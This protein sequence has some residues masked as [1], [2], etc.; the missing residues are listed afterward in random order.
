VRLA[1]ALAIKAPIQY[2]VK[3]AKDPL[4]TFRFKYRSIGKS[5]HFT[6]YIET[7]IAAAALKSLG[8][9]PR[10]PSPSQDIQPKLVKQE[11]ALEPSPEF[12]PGNALPTVNLQAETAI[13]MPVLL[14]QN[15]LNNQSAQSSLTKKDILIL[16]KHYRGSSDGL[17]GL[18]EKDLAILLSSYRVSAQRGRFALMLIRYRV[19][20]QMK[21][22]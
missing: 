21:H 22:P 14:Q 5:S 8:I 13:V 17:E 1:P 19:I 16:I 11:N 10:S 20:S 2:S 18:P 12:C 4:V 9:I 15:S 3:K 6:S 7:H